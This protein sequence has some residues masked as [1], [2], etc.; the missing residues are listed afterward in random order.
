[1]DGTKVAYDDIVMSNEEMCDVINS[2][3]ESL[4]IEQTT[5]MIT[6]ICKAACSGT[7]NKWEKVTPI[8]KINHI[9]REMYQYGFMTALYLFNEAI[10]SRFE[11]IRAQ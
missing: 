8:A 9:G 1:M 3:M 11:E 6:E 2:E 10:K 4:G 7:G 5:D